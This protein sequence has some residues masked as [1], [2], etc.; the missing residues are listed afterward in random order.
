MGRAGPG[1]D[2]IVVP[3]AGPHA[4]L[5]R[6]T[7]TALIAWPVAAGSLLRLLQ[8]PAGTSGGGAAGSTVAAREQ[9]QRAQE[10]LEVAQTLVEAGAWDELAVAAREARRGLQEGSDPWFTAAALE[11]RALHELWRPAELIAIGRRAREACVRR[12]GGPEDP[13]G[14]L[15]ALPPGTA[16]HVLFIDT[17]HGL[18]LA[19]QGELDPALQLLDA[20]QAHVD[21]GAAPI[22][23]ARFADLY[24]AELR[25]ARG[26]ADK[27]RPV[28]E[29]ASARFPGGREATIAAALLQARV[30]GLDGYRGR[31]EGDPGHRARAEG[32]LALVPAARARVVSALGIPDGTLRRA[33][34]G[35]ADGPRDRASEGAF[36]SYD[37]R[38]PWSPPVVSFFSETLALGAGD[39][40]ALLSHE[41]VHAGSLLELGPAYLQLPGWVV[42]GMASFAAGELEL[43]AR[44]AIAGEFYSAP[45]DLLGEHPERLFRPDLS[46][47]P[48]SPRALFTTRLALAVLEET[49][50]PGGAR[51]LLDA[52]RAGLGFDEAVRR[53]SGLA[54]PDFRRAAE[55]HAEQRLLAALEPVRDALRRLHEARAADPQRRLAVAAEVLSERAPAPARPLAL[56]LRAKAFEELGRPAE[57][58]LSYE[59]LLSDPQRPAFL[60]EQA[61]LG[62]GRA[63]AAAGRVEEARRVLEGLLRAVDD[64][65]WRS[66]IEQDLAG[67]ARRTAR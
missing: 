25:L 63:L 36:T 30:T 44:E 6:A 49:P 16:S 32:L 53:V 41:L 67:L 8:D 39:P 43:L 15:A 50:G 27:A 5:L 60:E 24:A 37:W 3:L 66:A 21:A 7:A 45:A 47:P 2:A 42:E 28:L 14:S 55:E 23:L 19:G 58:G 40:L 31:F 35:V 59:Q 38:R 51:A 9:D 46:A 18:A 54:P 33:V 48:A 13:A 56:H 34:V 26:E 52:L 20:V 61:R 10:F 1:A 57:A 17:V 29:Q 65:R 11:A 12:G 22:G 4:P 64:G 62:Y